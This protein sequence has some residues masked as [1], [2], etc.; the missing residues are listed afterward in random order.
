MLQGQ[1]GKWVNGSQWQDIIYIWSICIITRNISTC[2]WSKDMSAGSHMK[3]ISI[4]QCPQV[5]QGTV[6]QM[7]NWWTLWLHSDSYH[8]QGPDKEVINNGSNTKRDKTNPNLHICVVLGGFYYHLLEPFL[9]DIKRC[10]KV[11]WERLNTK[12]Y[13]W[14]M[15]Q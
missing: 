15:G 9:H 2:G 8:I 6:L 10:E 4:I 11:A 13:N 14:H 7:H 12:D 5:G 1:S 3:A